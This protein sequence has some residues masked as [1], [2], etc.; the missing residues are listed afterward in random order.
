M[1]LAIE[2][3]WQLRGFPVHRRS[4]QTW[5]SQAD[6][7]THLTTLVGLA[8][9]GLSPTLFWWMN[10]T[11]AA[12][13][14]TMHVVREKVFEQNAQVIHLCKT[15]D[16]FNATDDVVVATVAATSGQVAQMR[17]ATDD[18]VVA[19]VAATSGQVAQMRPCSP[20]DAGNTSIARV[21]WGNELVTCKVCNTQF[22]RSNRARHVKTIVH[23][24]AVGQ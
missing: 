19:T 18:V 23:I 21:Q 1:A 4:K 17:P 3:L 14:E 5:T 20:E 12:A 16:R 2:S 15:L 8:R 13:A 9:C 10:V 11:L 22:R 24:A 7:A 6:T